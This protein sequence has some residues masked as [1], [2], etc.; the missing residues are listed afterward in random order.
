MGD[1]KGFANDRNELRFDGP[2]LE[3][4]IVIAVGSIPVD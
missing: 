1:E 4:R 3:T 2:S